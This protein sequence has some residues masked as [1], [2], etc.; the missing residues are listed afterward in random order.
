MSPATAK[1][2][3]ICISRLRDRQRVAI[4][5]CRTWTENAALL[6]SVCPLW[7]QHAAACLGVAL[8]GLLCVNAEQLSR[9]RLFILA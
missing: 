5:V 2:W 7:L 9:N 6:H 3:K 8:D 4:V 1:D